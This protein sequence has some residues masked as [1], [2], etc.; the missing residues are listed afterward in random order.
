[1][2]LGR[3]A[4]CAVLDRLV[5]AAL[6]GRSG[7]L[8]LSG[9][10][11][12]GKTALLNYVAE[13][14][15]G[16][17]VLRTAGVEAENELAFA[18]LHQ[19]CVPL[20]GR[21]DRLPSPQAAA[22]ATAFALDIGDPPGRFLVG[23]AVLSLL[24]DLAEEKPVVCIVDDAHWLDQVSAQT[25]AFVARRLLAERVALVFVVREGSTHELDGLEEL[26][27]PG[28]TDVDARALL[29]SILTGPVDEQVRARIVAE[30][31]GNPLALLEL[32]RGLTPAELAG[33]FG[34]LKTT[35]V[36][37]Q[38]EEGFRS[39]L[40]AL[41]TTTR[42]LLL[43]AAAEPVGDAIVLRR[44]LELLGIA[45]DDAVADAGGL[46]SL[47]THVR[48]RH[49]LVRS[50]IYRAASA[51]ERSAAHR[52]LAEVTDPAVDPDRRAWHLAA[53]TTGPDE[54]VAVELE[55]SAGRAQA[56][57][58]MAAAAAFLRR[59]V[60]LTR[61]PT[62]RAER[63][64]AA[65][66]ASLKAGAFDEAL[67][68]VATAE[69]GVVDEFQR[70]RIDLVRGHVAFASGLGSDAP[71]LLL[72]AA[73][74]LEAFDVELARE[75]YLTAWGAAVFAGPAG[76]GILGEI[77]RAVRG[78]PAP[79]RLRPLDLLVDGFA[80]LATDGRASAAPILHRAVKALTALPVEDVL[81]WGWAATGASDAVWDDEGTR[82]IATRHV[83]LVRD[84]GALAE[85]PI[86]LAA[87]GIAKAWTGDFAATASLIAESDSVAAAT[88][89]PI[90]PYA[91]LRL[92]SLQGDEREAAAPIASAI[93]QAE[94]GG[95]GMAA[96]WANWS[97][98]VLYNGLAR[99]QEAASAA[100][101]ATADAFEPWASMWALPELVEAAARI[102]DVGLAHDALER[103]AETTQPAGTN[104]ALGIEARSRA[105][106]NERTAADAL[107]RDAIERFERTELRPEL[108]RARLLY[109]EW[110]R[111]EGRRVEAREQLRAAHDLFVEI[112]MHA[113]AERARRE[114]IATGEKVYKRDVATRDA[115]TAQEAQIA[116]LASE[117]RTN[118]EIGA[119]LFLSPRTVEW[120]L[121]HVF[122]KL[123]LSSRR[124]LR[125]ALL[126][127]GDGAASAA[128]PGVR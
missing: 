46:I 24:A 123:S 63:A 57:G 122:T 107:Y 54:N 14:A 118:P 79:Q 111:R 1:M 33:G 81:R 126:R 106:V 58:G 119:T 17:R 104:F 94:T 30:A 38:I 99:Y 73:K 55:R 87:L 124:E 19:L 95:Q 48:F 2:L 93:E 56:R 86:H 89:T 51:E 108:A 62:R 37:R 6:D 61:D 67:G 35:P 85:L 97:A 98:A 91:L 27:V 26:V 88:G 42:Q 65:A 50:A 84:A 47:D 68:L 39:R 102:G 22:L 13:R 7:V 82:A 71:P 23:L 77:G 76:G 45:A 10:P 83:Q 32:T 3:T 114:L 25:L 128:R 96:A 115:L 78:L 117:G 125:A 74:R 44:A 31:R 92:R 21:L 75:T 66:E 34:P 64:L 103:L 112:G 120:H 18:G 15:S 52:A 110:L 28:L 53:A 60:A 70:A 40:R 20:L 69:A 101:K 59:A 5:T 29:N 16:C 109:G 121:G 4:E 100:R 113:F 49:P 8:V 36:T 41:D 80:L 127:S 11:G 105:L 72:Q 116:Q 90:A 9:E 43:T 12:V